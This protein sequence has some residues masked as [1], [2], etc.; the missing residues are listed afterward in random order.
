MTM[1]DNLLL[2]MLAV[3]TVNLFPGPDMLYIISQSISHGKRFGLAA[4]LGIG[5]GCFVHIFAVTIGLSAIL[6]ESSVAF[7]MIKYV[8][9][10]YLLYLGITSLLKK[11]SPLFKQT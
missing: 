7:T 6:F 10:G 5:A 4:A 11:E 8:G 3:L 9:A 2:Y 1:T